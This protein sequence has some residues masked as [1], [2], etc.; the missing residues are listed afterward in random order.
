M[1]T[2]VEGLELLESRRAARP[3]VR[4]TGL[5]GLDEATGGFAEAQ[6]WIVIGAPG[7]GRSALACQLAWAIGQHGLV[8]QLVSRREPADLM[9]ARVAS[10]V[11]KVPL[12]HMWTRGMTDADRERLRLVRSRIDAASLSVLGPE[13]VSLADAD[14]PGPTMPEALVVDDAHLA[15]GMFPRRVA[16]LAA[17]GVLVVLTM[18]RHR[19]MSDAGI[20]PTWGEVADFVLEIDRP[21]LIDRS[22]VRPG[23]ADLH[24]LRNRWGPTRSD[25]VAFQG[26]YSRFVDMTSG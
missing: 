20:D 8:T 3:D 24:L 16:A 21:D 13:H 2:I 23:E 19:V 1:V 22:S 7:Q 9:A 5:T 6:V 12:N 11:A 4:T 18:P 14:I 17:A 26:H 15:G 10:V 25:V